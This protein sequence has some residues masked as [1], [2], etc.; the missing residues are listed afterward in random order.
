M[1]VKLLRAVKAYAHEKI[2]FA[3]EFAPLFI[4]KQSICLQRITDSLAVP[5]VLFLQRNNF[6]KEIQPH[7]CRLTTLPGE[8]T[9]RQIQL[10]IIA[11]QLVKYLLSHPMTAGAE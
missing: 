3:K 7:Q 9:Y 8:I 6:L 11:Y 10:H 2:I 5:A 1:V 4:Q